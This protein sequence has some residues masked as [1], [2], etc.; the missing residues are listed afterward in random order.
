MEQNETYLSNLD[1]VKLDNLLNTTE[2]S[3]T[4]FDDITSKIVNFYTS[5]IDDYMIKIKDTM[6]NVSAISTNIIEN[7]LVGL[8]NAIYFMGTNIEQLGIRDDLSEAMYK[9]VYNK[10]YLEAQS[11]ERDKKLTQATLQAMADNKS[12]YENTLNA[13]YNRAYKMVKFKIDSASEMVR[14]LS[15]LLSK[16]ISEMNNISPDSV[17][18]YSTRKTLLEG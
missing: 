15:K 1:T 8:T 9:E 10:E 17:E 14:T 18:G 2:A 3:V 13:I 12:V 6:Q 7:Y 16:R 5:E 4:Y 11:I